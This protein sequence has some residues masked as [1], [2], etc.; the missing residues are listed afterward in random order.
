MDYL[1]LLFSKAIYKACS[2]FAFRVSFVSGVCQNLQKLLSYC[3]SEGA[4]F[5]T[6]LC[7]KKLSEKLR[8]WAWQWQTK[9][10]SEQSNSPLRMRSKIEIGANV[11]EYTGLAWKSQGEVPRSTSFKE[12]CWMCY[13][14]SEIWKIQH[15]TCCWHTD[16][17]AS[18]PWACRVLFNNL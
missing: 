8:N 7:I 18:W 5:S 9:I 15:R 13:I 17:K 14:F 3:Q 11:C 6:D 12:H 1:K 4:A 10:M 16:L 2:L